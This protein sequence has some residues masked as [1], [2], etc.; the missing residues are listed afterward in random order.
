[1][2][3]HFRRCLVVETLGK[4]GDDEDV[5]EE[6][7]EQSNGRL[8]EEVF[9]GL[10]HLRFICPVHLPG[11]PRKNHDDDDANDDVDDSKW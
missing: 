8:D 2:T 3:D 7:D 4:D 11:L 9:V 5:D 6:G 1:M 10:F